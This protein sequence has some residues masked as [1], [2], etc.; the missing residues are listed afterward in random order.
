MDAKLGGVFNK[1][2][3]VNDEKEQESKKKN[4]TYQDLQDLLQL[5]M[6][7]GANKEM[8][9][10]LQQQH[11]ILEIEKKNGELVQIA[12]FDRNLLDDDN[13]TTL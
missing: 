7:S 12:D 3:K 11:T 6:Y 10:I 9:E 2:N 5:A 8:I 13:S 1:L 4:R